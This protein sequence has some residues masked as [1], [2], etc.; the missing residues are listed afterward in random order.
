MVK[1]NKFHIT[2]IVSA[3]ELDDLNHVNNIHYIKWV[4]DVAQKHW[5]ILSNTNLEA[6][7]VWVV[8][9]HEV[10]YLSSARLND[11][12]TVKT[13]IGDSYGVKS[14]RFVEIKKGDKLIA[15]AKTIWCLLD[16]MTMKP[17]R[18][19]SE[20]IKILQSDSN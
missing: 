13:W 20:I 6:K 9:R 16:K 10:D 18:I 8:L 1:K 4:Q 5:G 19:P 15:N 17:V 14:E 3:N 11:E 12:I 2:L 7:Y